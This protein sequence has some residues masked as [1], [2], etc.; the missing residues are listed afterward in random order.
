M[1]ATAKPELLLEETPVRD[2]L[3]AEVLPS[4]TLH[5][6]TRGVV[7]DSIGVKHIP[8]FCA[9]CGKSGGFVPEPSKDFA[10]YLCDSPC[11]EKWQH[12]MGYMAVPQEAFWAIARAEQMERL[13]H[14]MSEIEILEALRDPNHWLH[15]LLRSEEQI[16]DQRRKR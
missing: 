9:N 12:L 7:I 15:T 13:G 4:S 10:F 3:T 5:D 8:I 14:L 1:V 2:D 6:T 11:G 16:K